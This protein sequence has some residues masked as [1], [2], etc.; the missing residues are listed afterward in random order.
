MFQRKRFLQRLFM[1]LPEL[2]IY[3]KERRK[4]CFEQGKKLKYIHLREVLYL[5][6]SWFLRLDRLARKFPG[7]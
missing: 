6:F 4:Y 3:Y 7:F 1:P 2:E 5:L